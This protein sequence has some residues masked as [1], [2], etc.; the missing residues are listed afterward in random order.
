LA[1]VSIGAIFAGMVKVLVE[2][3]SGRGYNTKCSV[4]N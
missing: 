4:I 1:V 2:V 3:I